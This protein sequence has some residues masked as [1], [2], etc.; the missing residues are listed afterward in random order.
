MNKGAKG[1]SHANSQWLKA[2]SRNFLI[3]TV[4]NFRSLLSRQTGKLPELD[5]LNVLGQITGMMVYECG[6]L[7]RF[8][9]LI[10]DIRFGD[11]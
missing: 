11:F 6:C 8:V 3:E 5:P 1:S 7:K 4:Q 9:C 10:S 2:S